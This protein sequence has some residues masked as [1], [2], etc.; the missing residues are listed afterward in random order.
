MIRMLSKTGRLPILQDFP[1]KKLN[2][3][4]LFY[5]GNLKSSFPAT[6]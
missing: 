3:S 6:R 4:S 1:Q 2:G 5:V